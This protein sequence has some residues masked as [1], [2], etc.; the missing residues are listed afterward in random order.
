MSQPP[1]VDFVSHETATCREKRQ[2]GFVSVA[3]VS[4][5]A[6]LLAD[7]NSSRRWLMIFYYH[8]TGGA[9]QEKK[10]PKFGGSAAR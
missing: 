1:V 2:D 6:D 9:R 3:R 5:S 10:P 4:L 7:K 8:R